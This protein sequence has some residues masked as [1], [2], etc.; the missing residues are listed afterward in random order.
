MRLNLPLLFLR[1]YSI[2]CALSHTIAPPIQI[3]VSWDK[4]RSFEI[5]PEPV[6]SLFVLH[7]LLHS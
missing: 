1:K 5:F 6:C 2:E 4:D 3:I 7:D